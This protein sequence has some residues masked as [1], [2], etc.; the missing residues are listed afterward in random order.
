[1]EFTFQ[2]AGVHAYGQTCHVD[3]IRV[4]KRKAENETIEPYEPTTVLRAVNARLKRIASDVCI[5]GVQVWKI[6]FSTSLSL[7]NI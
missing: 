5:R 4:S 6:I 1:M 7:S 3:I 2:D